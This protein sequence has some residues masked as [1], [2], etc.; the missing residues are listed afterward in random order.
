M[1][2]GSLDTQRLS[3]P[4][5]EARAMKHD[6]MFGNTKTSKVRLPE[7]SNGVGVC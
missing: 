3:F 5:S 6:E 2:V 4:S 1:A 7:E